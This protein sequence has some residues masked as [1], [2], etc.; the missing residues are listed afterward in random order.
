MTGIP[1]S[2][3]TEYIL[4]LFRVNWKRKRTSCLRHEGFS[5]GIMSTSGRGKRASK[6]VLAYVECPRKARNMLS[7]NYQPLHR[8]VWSYLGQGRPEKT[9]LAL[10]VQEHV[11]FVFSRSRILSMEA[12]AST[13]S[14][15]VVS[16]NTDIAMVPP[17]VLGT[18][19]GP[20]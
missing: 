5:A 9:R 8:K 2:S 15:M 18:S 16:Q 11:V 12:Q 13:S 20:R 17:G 4:I 7:I 19:M 3:Y 10:I 1:S 14:S 6:S